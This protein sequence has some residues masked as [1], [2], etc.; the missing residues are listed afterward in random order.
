MMEPSFEKQ[1]QIDIFTRMSGRKFS[2]VIVDADRFEAGGH[3][4][5]VASKASLIGWKSKSEREKD[6]FDA[7]ALRRLQGDPKAFD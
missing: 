1:C 7:A 5:A 6:Q 4:I 2:D 3:Q